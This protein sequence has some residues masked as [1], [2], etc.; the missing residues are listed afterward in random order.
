MYNDDNDNNEH[1]DLKV[2]RRKKEARSAK[3]EYDQRTHIHSTRL[4]SV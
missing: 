1:S 3:R 4:K 2:R